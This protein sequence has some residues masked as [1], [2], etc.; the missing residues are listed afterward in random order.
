MNTTIIAIAGGS[1]SGKTTFAKRLLAALG[2]DNAAMVAQDS[3]YIDQSH[4]FDKDGGAV[5]FDHPSALDFALMAQHL[6]ELRQGLTIQVPIYDF[7]TH[8]RLQRAEPLAPHR[9]ILVDG[10]LILSQENLRPHFDISV[11]IDVEEKV[12]FERRLRRDTTE[13]G[14]T[15]EGVREQFYRQVAPMHEEFVAPSAH[16]AQWRVGMSDFDTRLSELLKH[17]NS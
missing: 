5:N 4:R 15:A 10:I 14:R 11:F 17:L 6:G 3:Y 8:K 2:T 1:G 13:R 12:R 9:Y 16:H 7:A